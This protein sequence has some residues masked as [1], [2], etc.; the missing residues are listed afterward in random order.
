MR[1]LEAKEEGRFAHIVPVHQEILTLLRHEGVD[2]SDGSAAG[3]FV[4]HISQIARRIG[5]PVGAV[6]DGGHAEIHLPAVQIILPQQ[7]VEALEDV[8]RCLVF[9][10]KLAQIDALA[11]F[12]DEADVS[13]DDIPQRRGVIVLL[14]L[15]PELREQLDD[16]APLR[17]LH[18]QG[19]GG[20]V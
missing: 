15:V 20:E 6:L 12:Q 8:R 18:F 2:V 3:G 1:E 9:L 5:Q 16:S 19:F 13:Q 7:V 14:K 17:G 10:R 4:D 11:V